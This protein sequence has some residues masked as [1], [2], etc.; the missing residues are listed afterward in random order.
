MKKTTL[1]ILFAASCISSSA[2]AANSGNFYIQGDLLSSAISVSDSDEFGGA[3]FGQRLSLGYAFE[4][5]P[6]R[7]AA[8]F[9]NYGKWSEEAS[10]SY[11][12]GNVYAKADLKIKSFG[13]SGFRS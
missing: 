6:V 9:T 4:Q 5:V 10:S 1:A 8:D 12:Y 13:V 7:I 2:L 3:A 11:G